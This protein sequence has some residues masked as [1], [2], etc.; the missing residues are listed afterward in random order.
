MPVGVD[1]SPRKRRCGDPWHRLPPRRPAR[2]ISA[3]G[4]G[5]SD[6]GMLSG[7]RHDHRSRAVPAC[8]AVVGPD[9]ASDIP[10]NGLAIIDSPSNPLGSIVSPADAVRLSRA[11]TCVVVD[12]RFAEYSEFSLL[13]LARELDNVVVMRSFES[14]A[15]L[16]ETVLRLGGGLAAAGRRYLSR[17]RPRWNQ[18]RSRG[19]WRRCENQASVAATLKLV[20][21]ERSRL[22][23]FLRK[24]VVPR[25][26]PFVGAIYHGPR[27]HCVA[28]GPHR[29]AREAGDS[30]PRSTGTRTGAICP[31]RHR[32]PDGDGSP[33][34]GAPGAWARAGRLGHQEGAAARM[35]SR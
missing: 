9:F 27:H 10:E 14:W 29:W 18:R 11:C 4:H 33:A 19:R 31:D 6:R 28:P 1:S 8:D 26:T 12:E 3:R 35:A 22:Y 13:P 32:V 25:T 5:E 30:R 21:E 2:R 17:R 23:R 16:S 15:G 7:I 24:V 20:R 34:S